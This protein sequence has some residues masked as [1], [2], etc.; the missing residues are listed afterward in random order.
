MADL[1]MLDLKLTIHRTS[2]PYVRQCHLN[3][4]A[5]VTHHALSAKC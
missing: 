3:Q 1:H 2:E 5:I 4:L